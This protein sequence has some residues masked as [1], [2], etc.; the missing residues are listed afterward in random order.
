[1]RYNPGAVVSFISPETVSLVEVHVW[2]RKAALG[3]DLVG[4]GRL[5]VVEEVLT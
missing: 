2:R 1:M 4:A 3:P 5:A